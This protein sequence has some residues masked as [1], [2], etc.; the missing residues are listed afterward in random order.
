ML[1]TNVETDAAGLFVASS[2]CYGTT[3]DWARFGLL[4]LNDG[5]FACDTL[6]SKPWVDFMKTPA[7]A[8]NGKY[9]GTF[10]LKEPEEKNRLTDVPGD[11][12]FADGFQGQRIYI[13]PSKELVVVRLGFGMGNFSMNDFLREV[14]KTLP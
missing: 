3:R 4:F 12:F 9:A 8:S 10:W 11:I 7:E 2:Y 1:N 13:V 6:L 5:V 14:I